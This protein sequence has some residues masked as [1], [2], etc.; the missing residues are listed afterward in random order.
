[1]GDSVG[2]VNGRLV[3]LMMVTTKLVTL[4]RLV[5]VVLTKNVL[6]VVGLSVGAVIVGARVVLNVGRLG[7]VVFA[8][9]T[10]FGDR[11]TMALIKSKESPIGSLISDFK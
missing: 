4:S 1:M 10:M 9:L 8:E 3:L 11:I 5:V 2:K 7:S 6:V